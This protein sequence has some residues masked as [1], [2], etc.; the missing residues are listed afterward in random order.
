LKPASFKRTEEGKIKCPKCLPTR[1]L[2]TFAG[3]NLA[4]AQSGDSSGFCGIEPKAIISC[5]PDGVTYLNLSCC[6]NLGFNGYYNVFRF[7]AG[8]KA[9]KATLS[10]TP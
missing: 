10:A 6:A 7:M 1:R 4:V 8:H 3:S 5:L 2:T 9:K